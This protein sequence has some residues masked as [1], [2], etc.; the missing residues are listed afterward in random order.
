MAAHD[1]TANISAVEILT[2]AAAGVLALALALALLAATAAPTAAA[3][4]LEPVDD[5]MSFETCTLLSRK[6]DG[7]VGQKRGAGPK[8]G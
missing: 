7:V 3:L 4:L 1:P 6:V 2:G 8:R 5:D